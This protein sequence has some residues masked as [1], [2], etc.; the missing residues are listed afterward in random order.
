MRLRTISRLAILLLVSI[1]SPSVRAATIYTI[2]GT[3]SAN[4]AYLQTWSVDLTSATGWQN[5]TFTQ[6]TRGTGVGTS[7]GISLSAGSNPQFYGFD[8]NPTGSSAVQHIFRW[9]TPTDW[10]NDSNKTTIATSPNESRTSSG[11]AFYNN[12]YYVLS[13]NPDSTGTRTLLKY[14]TAA[15]FVNNTSTNLGNFSPGTLGLGFDIAQDGSV[16]FMASDANHNVAGTYT[17]YSWPSLNSFLNNGLGGATNLGS[18]TPGTIIQGLAVV[19]EPSTLPLCA[20]VG[21]VG[22]TVAG[23]RKRKAE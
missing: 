5:A 10:L 20:V 2:G 11:S 22:W 6:A 1:G 17:L 7:S 14:A 16:Y 21:L 12:E 19:P 18:Q 8:G 4:S 15:D 3:P 9:A 13:G 23:R